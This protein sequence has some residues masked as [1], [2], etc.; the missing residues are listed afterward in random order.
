V[1]NM[2]GQISGDLGKAGINIID[3]LNRSR[4]QIAVTLL[5]VDREPGEA[6]LDQMAATDGVLSVRC[7]GCAAK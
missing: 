3:M 6:T 7:L 4:E 2:V 1:P 5:D